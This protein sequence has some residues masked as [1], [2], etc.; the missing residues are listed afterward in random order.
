MLTAPFRHGAGDNHYVRDVGS[1]TTRAFEAALG[2]L[3][4]GTALAFSSG[5]A[6]IAAVV[7]GRPAGTVAVVPVTPV[8][9][10]VT[11]FA[12][13]AR[14]G[15][16]TVRRVDVTDTDA[17]LAALDGAGLLWLETVD[18]PVARRRRPAGSDR[19]RRMR[20]ARSSPSTRRSR[21]R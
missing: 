9:G 3:D 8:R 16:M 19:G 5:M 15:R 17:V 21:R 1:Q 14:L 4:G 12:E 13:Q 6:A 7:E 2:A 11:I 10:T 20:P 18:Q